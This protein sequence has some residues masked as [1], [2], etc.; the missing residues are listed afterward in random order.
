[1]LEVLEALTAI[2]KAASYRTA[3]VLAFDVSTVSEY[4]TEF[5]MTVMAPEAHVVDSWYFYTRLLQHSRQN[6]VTFKFSRRHFFT[7]N[8]YTNRVIT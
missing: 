2:R 7:A 5:G 1:M 6:T 8:L 4:L 3:L